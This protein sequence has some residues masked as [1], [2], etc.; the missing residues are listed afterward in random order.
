[1]WT[2]GSETLRSYSIPHD[3]K[4]VVGRFES[5]AVCSTSAPMSRRE[6]CHGRSPHRDSRPCRS[7]PARPDAAPSHRPGA[8]L[9]RRLSLTASSSPSRFPF[10]SAAF[11]RGRGLRPY[12][13]SASRRTR[14]DTLRF[15]DP[16]GR[17][18]DAR[19]PAQ[20]PLVH[21][22]SRPHRDRHRRRP[23]V[24][25]RRVRP[26]RHHG[27]VPPGR[28]TR[29]RPGRPLHPRPAGPVPRGRQRARPVGPFARG[30][31]P[32]DR[33][34]LDR[35]T[36]G[37]ARRS[38]LR[39]PGRRGPA[40]AAARRSLARHRHRLLAGHGPARLRGRARRR[41]TRAGR[42]HARRRTRRRTPG[43]VG[44]RAGGAAAR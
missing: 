37:G 44:R 16:S 18:H 42:C 41:R 9:Q 5:V 6:Q 40:R 13:V 19:R 32:A 26:R 14:R 2:P 21:P 28:R 23:P 36:A 15:A 7:G 34:H 35:G 29:C 33:S 17:P 27:A 22:L 25:H 20:N 24:A 1:M 43:P 3:G 30:A 4:R 10:L 12:P 38:R 39:N 11:R 8:G 31:D